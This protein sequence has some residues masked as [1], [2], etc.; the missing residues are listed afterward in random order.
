MAIVDLFSGCGGL[1]LGA[2]NA[3]L[4]PSFAFDLD[5]ILTS[6]FS[7]NHPNANFQLS[8]V[9]DLQ[10]DSILRHT[11]AKRIDLLF[12]GP[13]CQAFSA[14]GKRSEDD[15]RRSLIG[16]FFRLVRELRPNYFL[17]ENVRG[18]LFDG[19]KSVLFDAIYSLPPSY[20]LI[21]PLV[22]DAA[23]FGAATKRPRVFVIGWDKEYCDGVDVEEI[24]QRKCEATTVSQAI[25]DLVSA[26]N[27][28]VKDGFD[29]W[30]ISKIGRPSSY[31]SKMRSEDG[32]FTGHLRTDHSSIVKKRFRKLKAGS[33]DPV[34]KHY[35]LS[36]DGQC[37]TLRAGTGVDHGSFQSVRPIHPSEARVITVREA[38]RLQG[39]PDWF[40]FHPTIWHSFRM[41]GNSVSPIVAQVLFE[42]IAKK[43]QSAKS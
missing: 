1:S 6:S 41:I 28:C 11:G 34:G 37:P 26:K 35:K 2:T 21:G 38:A 27:L 23:E 40:K 9:A 15:P 4:K 24:D 17:M 18:L 42:L 43:Y 10:G 20:E 14:I 5:P 33:I 32:K 13:P 29:I 22:L 30:K 25:R 7:S 31:S 16:H 12:G 19:S 36:W 8:D 3:G 39:F